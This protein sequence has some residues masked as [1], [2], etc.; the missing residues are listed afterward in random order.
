ML[1]TT[2]DDRQIALKKNFLEKEEEKLSFYVHFKQKSFA[3]PCLER[4]EGR[5]RKLLGSKQANEKKINIF[6]QMFVLSL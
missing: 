3:L 5:E 1:T 4:T 6:L 2:S